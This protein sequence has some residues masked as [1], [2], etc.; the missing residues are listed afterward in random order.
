MFLSHLSGGEAPADDANAENHFLS[1]LSGG[2]VQ[3][4]WH[5]L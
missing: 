5:H 3:Y 2:E 1:H 4:Q